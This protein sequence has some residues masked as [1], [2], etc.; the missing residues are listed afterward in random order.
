M[1][2]TPKRSEKLL[3]SGKQTTTQQ[4]P[5]KVRYGAIP[6]ISAEPS[7]ARLTITPWEIVLLVREFKIGNDVLHS[8]NILHHHLFF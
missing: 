7:Q 1:R 5:E 6:E 3:R 8:Y 4:M 2:K